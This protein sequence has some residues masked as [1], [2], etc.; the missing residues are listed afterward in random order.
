MLAGAPYGTS[1]ARLLSHMPPISRETLDTELSAYLGIKKREREE[2]NTNEE[3]RKMLR[4]LTDALQEHQAED[5]RQFKRIDETLVAHNVRL[6]SLEAQSVMKP[7]PLGRGE[8]IRPPSPTDTGSF[9]IGPQ[10]WA[11]FSA[12]VEQL[13][14]DKR[15]ADG[16]TKQL[17]EDKTK[18]QGDVKF[19]LALGGGIITLIGAVAV[20]VEW[21]M[22]HIH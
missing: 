12:H 7:I 18:L 22:H 4:T 11:Q 16:V 8:S 21:S 13:T 9:K 17:R 5:A 10:E 15:V 20:A 19:I 2:G 6:T 1:S 3:I 14:E